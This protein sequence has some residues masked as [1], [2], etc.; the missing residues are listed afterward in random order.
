MSE[1]DI[2]ILKEELTKIKAKIGKYAI[3]GDNDYEIVDRSGDNDTNVYFSED[4]E[5]STSLHKIV[6]SIIDIKF[7]GVSTGGNLKVGTYTFYFTLA[8]SDDNES[9]FVG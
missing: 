5:Y 2:N 1:D 7:D 6:N 4:F 9:D 3:Y 8:D